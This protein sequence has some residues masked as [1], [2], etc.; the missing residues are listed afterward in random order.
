MQRLS[1]MDASFFYLETP[2]SHM[3][4]IGVIVIDGSTMPGGY[5]FEKIRALFEERLDVLPPF[6][7]RPVFVPFGLDH[8]VWIEDADFD[9]D[10]HIRRMA[11]PAP[12]SPHDLADI[13]GHISSVPLDRS[14]PL[15]ELTVVEGL[16]HDQV[17]LVTKMHHSSIDG[18]SGADLLVHLFDLEPAPPAPAPPEVP[19]HGEPV[20]SDVE[21]VTEALVR[22]VRRPARLVRTLY[23]TSQSAVNVVRMLLDS[24]VDAALPLTA[25]RIMFSGEMT[26]HRD[27]AF[28]RADLEDLKV[29]KDTFGTTVNDVVL[30]ACTRSL[31][32]Y[33]IDHDDLPDKPLI[34]SVPV[35]VRSGE[36]ESGGNKVSA[37]FAALPVQ[38]EDPVDQLSEIHLSM[39]SAKEL[40]HAIG[41]D[42]LQDW[43]ESMGPAVLNQASRLLSRLRQADRNTGIN[44]A[45]RVAIHNVVIS[46]VPGP[47][48]PLYVAGARMVATYPL[49]PVLF[50]AGLNLT[51]L[52]NMGNVDISA[53][54]CTEL[55]PDIFQLTD[56][57]ADAVAELLEA[58]RA[59]Q[60][61]L[62]G[63]AK[64]AAKAKDDSKKARK[65]HGAKDDSK[66]AK[67]AKK[68][69]AVKTP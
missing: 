55:V 22:S 54:G 2:T 14:R 21:L 58:A 20:P 40:H 31:R 10:K 15:W 50:G 19:W 63:S 64:K 62:E 52:S 18:V 26:P 16:E 17:A 24:D 37:M 25:P 38:L 33:L 36:D 41:A 29:I 11:A 8:P 53:V 68:S 1:G 48:F 35:S 47:P 39:S 12:G 46:N 51:V 23:R 67:K 56:G 42:M 43:T 7:R 61:K 13:V 30:A 69:H 32:K 59:R 34:A 57:F 6:R 60:G 49:G 65:S 28:G 44:L 9:L 27:V 4:I 3:H 66:K 45:E 5:S